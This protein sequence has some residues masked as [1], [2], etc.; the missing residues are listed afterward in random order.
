M[1][2]LRALSNKVVMGAVFK[3]RRLVMTTKKNFPYATLVGLSLVMVTMASGVSA[4]ADEPQ[5]GDVESR[6]LRQIQ[7][8]MQPGMPVQPSAGKALQ[9]PSWPQKFDV[10]GPETD[11]FGF[12]VTQAGLIIIDVQ[13]QGPPITVTLRG[14]GLPPHTELGA[15]QIRLNH[16]VTQQDVARGVFWEI[17][18]GLQQP[19]PTQAVGQVTVQHPPANPA[20]VQAAASAQQQAAQQRIAQRQAEM[21][22]AS[23]QSAAQMEA[24]FQQRKVQ[25]EQQR[26]H[27]H[28]AL[29]AQAQ[30]MI[31][32][33]RMRGP[34]Q[35]R[36]R[37]IE[38]G[39]S[40]PAEATAEGAAEIET[41]GFSG[42][43]QTVPFTQ[44]TPS[45]S[46][47]VKMPERQVT[48]SPLI[49]QSGPAV[50][51]PVITSLSVVQGQPGDPVMIT[52][53]GFGEEGGEVHFVIGPGKDL[54]A[55]AGMVWRNDQIFA[56]VP[57]ATGVLGFNGT[58]YVQR[59]GDRL[60]L[61]HI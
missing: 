41:R 19:G 44:A 46:P 27:R 48:T 38:G 12:A 56:T 3:K 18:I 22:Q 47:M 1:R 60:S 14:P 8:P 37:G 45:A 28:A 5:Q 52:G 9:E 31:D 29:M 15:G 24:A 21:Q 58:V 10:R 53:N 36:T 40:A 17:S 13:A 42:V 39:D 26:Q 7:R 49:I 59:V 11:G 2:N 25:F 23:A 30:S 55:P 43:R 51:A 32:R 57:E 20:Q 33:L 35:V 4:W 6:G 16:Q 50:Q 54:I 34:G 61:I